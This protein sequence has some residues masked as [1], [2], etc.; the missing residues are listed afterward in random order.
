VPDAQR[1]TLRTTF[2]QVPE[3]Y[4]RARPSYPPRL[5]DDL[6]A[7]ARL[8]VGARIVEIG[9]G[10]GQATLPLAERGFAVTCVELGARLATIARQKLAGF[11]A[12]DVVV[13]DFDT[14]ETAE[15]FDGAV[16]FTS[17]HWLDPE[18]RFARV[19]SL[20]RP[21]GVLAVT[22]TSHVAGGDDFFVDV[23]ADYREVVPEDTASHEGG[24]RPPDDIEGLRFDEELFEP[25]ARHRYVWDVAYD[26]DAYIAVLT[27]YSGHRAL[28]AARRE[29]LFTRIRRRIEP[30]GGVRKTYLA[31]LDVA[32][33][34]L[35][36]RP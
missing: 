11:P 34:R 9:C 1:E 30:R 13:A 36:R 6:V 16:A 32:R 35:P 2:E 29:E 7:L 33:P 18:T 26:A 19:A 21:G 5:F 28:D 15:R 14:W 8:P 17:F 23:Q 31:T 12:V 20:L 10:T 4:A 3:L 25:V 27:T 24:P 22:S